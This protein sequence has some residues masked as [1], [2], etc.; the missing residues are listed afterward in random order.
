MTAR[1]TVKQPKIL[2]SEL[3]KIDKYFRKRKNTGAYAP[4]VTVGQSHTYGRGQILTCHKAKYEVHLLSECELYDIKNFL[5][6]HTRC[7][8]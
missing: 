2:Q 7:K 1:K 3:N 4:W 8:L 5:D 6:T